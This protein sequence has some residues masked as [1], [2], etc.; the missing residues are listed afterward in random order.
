[1]NLRCLCFISSSTISLIQFF[2]LPR[3]KWSTWSWLQPCFR[4]SLEETSPTVLRASSVCRE[5]DP[6]WLT[7]P[8][9][10]PGTRC[11]VS[12]RTITPPP[13]TLSS[14]WTFGNVFYLSLG[15]CPSY[16]CTRTSVLSSCRSWHTCASHLW[17][18]GLAPK[19]CQEPGGNTQSLGGVAAQVGCS[20]VDFVT[21]PNKCSKNHALLCHYSI[22]APDWGR[23]KFHSKVT[24]F[25]PSCPG[26]CGVRSTGCW[27]VSASRCV[28]LSTLCAR[29]A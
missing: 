26:S 7:W 12:V 23:D 11:L 25:F 18:P 27:S 16:N 20:A 9:T 21:C 29:C 2:F 6:R 14:A 8:W 15:L 4:M 28:C 24:C 19:T 5:L 10:L 22:T 13:S 3:Q 17:S 1:M